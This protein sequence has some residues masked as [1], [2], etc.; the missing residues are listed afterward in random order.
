MAR[1]WV[2]RAAGAT[3]VC[4]MASNASD[5]EIRWSRISPRSGVHIRLAAVVDAAEGEHA[6]KAQCLQ[7]GLPA[8]FV[9]VR[10]L[11][12]E[13]QP[14]DSEPTLDFLRALRERSRQVA[15]PI[16]DHA[17]G[18]KLLAAA[19]ESGIA[20]RTI[21][22][23]FGAHEWALPPAAETYLARASFEEIMTSAGER[24]TL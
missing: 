24:Q 19:Y 23:R 5:T 7:A 15:S 22:V 18:I 2:Q 8:D 13:Y 14:C 16:S 6:I 1:T 12:L 4:S 9:Y 21:D 10:Q 17:I 3:F 20:G 11:R